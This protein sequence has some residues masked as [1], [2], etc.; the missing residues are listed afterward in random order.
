MLRLLRHSYAVFEPEERDIPA[1]LVA[2]KEDIVPFAVHRMI[3]ACGQMQGIFDRIDTQ[4]VAYRRRNDRKPVPGITLSLADG[5]GESYRFMHIH[6]PLLLRFDHLGDRTDRVELNIIQGKIIADIQGVGIQVYH[7]NRH[8]VTVLGSKE[9]FGMLV[10]DIIAEFLLA[11]IQFLGLPC[12]AVILDPEYKP[13]RVVHFSV[14]I[15]IRRPE[16]EDI[17][18]A[19][20]QFQFGVRSGGGIPSAFVSS[21][22]SCYGIEEC[23]IIAVPGGYSSV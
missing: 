19:F 15:D 1:L 3:V 23:K 9:R 10:P 21:L 18:G 11:Q 14:V 22:S 7:R 17:G 6:N 16:R 12:L 20:H 2:D 8:I 13:R 5:I 4:T